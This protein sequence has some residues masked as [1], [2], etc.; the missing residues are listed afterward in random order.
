MKSKKHSSKGGH[1]IRLVAKIR[2]N[3]TDWLCF[4]NNNKGYI[5]IK[6]VKSQYAK[7]IF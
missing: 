5:Y 3:T 7:A 2:F 4:K 1:N 6:K